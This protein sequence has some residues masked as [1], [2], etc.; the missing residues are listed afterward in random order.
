MK[1]ERFFKSLR[2]NLLASLYGAIIGIIIS[3]LF[4]FEVWLP[5]NAS[6]IGLAIIA[7]LPVMVILFS[8]GGVVIGGVLGIVIYQIARLFRR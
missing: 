8:I 3:L 7:I 4:L 2:K 5:T 1:F 6:D